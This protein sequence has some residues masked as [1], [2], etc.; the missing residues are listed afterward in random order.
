MDYNRDERGRFLNTVQEGAAS[1]ISS[2]ALVPR[3]DKGCLLDTAHT[4]VASATSSAARISR[5]WRKGVLS[6]TEASP[7][8]AKSDDSWDTI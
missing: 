1:E 3:D 5:V 2:A 7:M 4:Q 8:P 6:H